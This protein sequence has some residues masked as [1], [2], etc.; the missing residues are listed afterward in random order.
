ML[1]TVAISS[2]LGAIAF[3]AVRLNYLAQSEVR[4][5]HYLNFPIQEQTTGEW[6]CIRTYP[7][8]YEEIPVDNCGDSPPDFNDVVTTEAECDT[9]GL[10]FQCD[11]PIGYFT[12]KS[13]DPLQVQ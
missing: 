10:V 2:G 6:R 7:D 4:W 3:G 8:R 13:W 11:R 9:V 5:A 12:T 1:S